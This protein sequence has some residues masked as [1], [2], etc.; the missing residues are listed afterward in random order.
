M[1]FCLSIISIVILSYSCEHEAPNPT[2][3][4]QPQISSLVARTE[5]PES[6]EELPDQIDYDTHI[7]IYEYH[8]NSEDST[9]NCSVKTKDG[10]TV[11][12][13]GSCYYGVPFDNEYVSD[14]LL[15]VG[16]EQAIYETFDPLMCEVGGNSAYDRYVFDKDSKGRVERVRH[17]MAWYQDVTEDG[18]DITNDIPDYFLGHLVEITYTENSRVIHT[19]TEEEELL[20][21][22]TNIYDDEERLS[23]QIWNMTGDR[24]YKAFYYY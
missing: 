19:Y 20:S 9:R 22:M 2:K 3:S 4:E 14:G 23:V 21:V 15:K 24:T 6:F 11:S 10:T 18:E 13:D 16:E 12:R 7:L 1:K 17:Y 8:E 5:V